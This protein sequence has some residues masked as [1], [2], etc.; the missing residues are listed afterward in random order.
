MKTKKQLIKEIRE[1]LTLLG[2]S[3][4]INQVIN[5]CNICLDDEFIVIYKKGSVIPENAT[6]LS[7]Y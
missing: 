1:N 4:D 3:S 7:V 2:T 5:M 6:V